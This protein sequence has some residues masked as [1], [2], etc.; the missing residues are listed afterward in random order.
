MDDSPG[1]VHFK[2]LNISF[3]FFKCGY[4]TGNKRLKIT[5]CPGSND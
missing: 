2:K 1:S 4:K 5:L 3:Y